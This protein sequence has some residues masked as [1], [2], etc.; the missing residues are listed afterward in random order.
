MLDKLL[1]SENQAD[2]RL[3]ALQRLTEKEGSHGERLNASAA[4]RVLHDLASS[5][6]T[7]AA[8]L[9]D[10]DDARSCRTLNAADAFSRSP[11]EPSFSVNRC[12]ARRRRSAWF[13]DSSSLSSIVPPHFSP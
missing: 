10:G 13:S 4:F 6:S 2:L 7:S 11:C 5:P 9:V 1:E 3:R 8:A 12:S